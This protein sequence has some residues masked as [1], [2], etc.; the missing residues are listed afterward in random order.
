MDAFEAIKARDMTALAAA[1]NPGPAAARTTDA[2]GATPLMFAAYSGQSEAV[3]LI[4]DAVGSLTLW[5]AI[6]VGDAGAVRAAIAGGSDPNERS[7]DGFPPLALAAFFR[8]SEVFE[9]LLPLT[10]DV[11]ARATNSQQVA[12]LHA[13]VA[14]RDIGMVE[15]LL[16]AGADPGLPQQQGI[17]PI[18]VTAAHGDGA[19]TALLVLFGADPTAR[20]DAGLDAAGH[21]RKGGHDWLAARLVPV[22]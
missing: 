8:Q 18:H 4:R 16:R 15:K 5:E 9:L 21:A 1:L 14:I 6:I 7:P 13:A 12:A 2:N 17:Q 20:D 3:A 22:R 19:G 11:N 10:A